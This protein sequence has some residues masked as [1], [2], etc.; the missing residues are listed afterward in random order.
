MLSI[1]KALRVSYGDMPVLIINAGGQFRAFSAFCTHLGCILNW[2]ENDKKI[3]CPCH[4]AI[5]DINGNLLCGPPPKPLQSIP[6]KIEGKEIYIG[7]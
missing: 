6:V 1:W 7:E 3:K 2:D 4:G 5:F